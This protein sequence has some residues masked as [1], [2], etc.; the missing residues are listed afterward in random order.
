MTTS[1]DDWPRIMHM[2]L[3]TDTSVESAP[4]MAPHDKIRLKAREPNWHDLEVLQR[5]LADARYRGTPVAQVPVE[6]LEGV[7]LFLSLP[8]EVDF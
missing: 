1:K 7:V 2:G 5:C 6:T 3:S 4:S 8:P